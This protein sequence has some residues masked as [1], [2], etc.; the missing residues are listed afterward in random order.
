M[1]KKLLDKGV[2]LELFELKALKDLEGSCAS[3][4]NLEVVD[5][6]KVKEDIYAL[7]NGK[8]NAL[9]FNQPKS[10]D[11]LKIMPTEG[12]IDFIEI[13]GIQSFCASLNSRKNL[14]VEK[15]INKQIAN[16]SLE[17]KIEDSLHIFKQ[18]LQIDKFEFNNNE[19]RT[20]LNNIEKN[21]IIV[22]DEEIEKDYAKQIAVN[23]G[24]L[25]TTSNYADQV[26]VKLKET[27]NGIQITK[28]TKPI[29]I[30]HS[31]IDEY[32]NKLQ[33]SLAN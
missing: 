19:K 1:L 23:L 21:Y 2:S 4:A 3:D 14:N 7:M 32:Y 29:L 31:K 25:S 8:N 30:S 22:I 26:I 27:V 17:D 10:C 33:L 9:K 5:Y 6:D 18:L 16:F 13:K 28:V 15:E 24:F 20:L 12:R 11:G